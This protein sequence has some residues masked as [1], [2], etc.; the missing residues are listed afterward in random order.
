VP[1]SLMGDVARERYEHKLRTFT[2]EQLAAA[3]PDMAVFALAGQDDSADQLQMI[4]AEMRTRPEWAE[5]ERR[6]AEWTSAANNQL[7][8][9]RWLAGLF[10]HRRPHDRLSEAVS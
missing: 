7:T 5:A 10:T 9:R 6:R 8:A 4:R 1:I 2:Y 3:A